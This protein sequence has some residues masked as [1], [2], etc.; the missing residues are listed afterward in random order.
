MRDRREVLEELDEVIRKRDNNPSGIDGTFLE[1]RYNDLQQELTYLDN[2]HMKYEVREKEPSVYGI[3][4]NHME[5]FQYIHKWGCSETWD[6]EKAIEICD[7]LNTLHNII[8]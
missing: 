7:A 5:A 6:N 2:T 4:N 3:W 1:C 8:G